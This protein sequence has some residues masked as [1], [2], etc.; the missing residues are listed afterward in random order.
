MSLEHL[1]ASF[2]LNNEDILYS[3]RLTTIMR[4]NQ[5]N[6]LL[7]KLNTTPLNNLWGRQ[8]ILTY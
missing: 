2:A 4:V 7:I 3:K 1:S 8:N 5:K 6:K